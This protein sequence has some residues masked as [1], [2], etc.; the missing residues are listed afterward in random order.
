MVYFKDLRDDLRVTFDV[1]HDSEALPEW[2]GDLV[3][4]Q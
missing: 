1:T 2:A 3:Q 4:Q